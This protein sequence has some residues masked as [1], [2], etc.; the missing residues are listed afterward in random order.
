M[1]RMVVTRAPRVLTIGVSW[2]PSP[3]RDMVRGFVD[4][5]ARELDLAR[6][7]DAVEEGAPTHAQLKGVLC[8]YG[9]HY[10]ALFYSEAEQLWVSFDDATVRP[11]GPSW[12]D[13]HA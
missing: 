1:G 9:C 11:I 3:P 7:F 8:Y 4:V 5:I 2:S 13:A 6:L 12:E 10:V